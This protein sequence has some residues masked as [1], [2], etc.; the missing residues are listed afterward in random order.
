MDDRPA[1]R[2]VAELP[3]GLYEWTFAGEKRG[4]FRISTKDMQALTQRA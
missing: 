2:Q 1:E 4:R 3:V